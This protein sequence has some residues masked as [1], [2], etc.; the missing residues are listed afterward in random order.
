MIGLIQMTVV[1]STILVEKD[2]ETVMMTSSARDCSS[3]ALTT[4]R[5]RQ[6]GPG[7]R[8]TTVVRKYIHILIVF[9]VLKCLKSVLKVLK[10]LKSVLKVS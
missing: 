9:K 1:K 2:R 6:G 5:P 4:V 10:C 3:A 8:L 7:T